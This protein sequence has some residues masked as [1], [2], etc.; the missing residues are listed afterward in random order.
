MNIVLH[1]LQSISAASLRSTVR[2]RQ[3][4][5][6]LLR[7]ALGGLTAIL[8]ALH[9]QQR[10]FL[11]GPDGI[12]SWPDNL[13]MLTESRA[14]TL[15]QFFPSRFGAEC[16]YWLGLVVSVLFT[17]GLFTRLS[18]ILFFLFT[19]SLYQ[20]NWYAIDGGGNLLIILAIY[21]MFADL[22]AL[23][24]DRILFR[25]RGGRRTR[26]LSGMLHNFAMTACLVQLSILYFV[27]AFF[28]IQGHVWSNGT[29]L[30]YILRTNGFSL[31]GWSE[32]IWR[33]ALLVTAGTYATILFE[34]VH[35]F[36]M[37]HRR[38]KYPMF[39]GAVC[40]HVGIGVLMGL[41]WFSLT[42]IMAHAPMFEDGEYGA[43]VE[44][45]RGRMRSRGRPPQEQPGRREVG[46]PAGY[47]AAG[48]EGVTTS[49]FGW[50]GI[51]WFPLSSEAIP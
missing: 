22:S 20:R 10:H 6:A 49:Q 25:N 7:I 28:K 11:W 29:A 24:L 13:A 12:V 23:S 32:L 47:R 14:W 17:L 19:W 41:P 4:G 40:L 5:A 50:A 15:Y 36:L 44:W 42:M 46:P 26:W 8:Y 16:L 21:L 2:R 3:T 30:Y 43:L 31:P 33:S 18:S 34:L 48:L 45:V 39:M 38:L 9:L 51:L 35:P 27:S 1:P 37:W